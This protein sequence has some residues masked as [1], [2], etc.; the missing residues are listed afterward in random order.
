MM[1]ANRIRS[2]VYS[3]RTR[4][5]VL[6]L[7][8][9]MI[10]VGTF[11][12]LGISGIQQ[13]GRSAEGAGSETLRAQA[14]EYLIQLTQANAAKS[15]LILQRVRRDA[16]ILAQYTA[17][18]F[19]NPTA[20]WD[21]QYWRAAE[22]MTDGPDGQFYNSTEDVTSIFIPNFVERDD[23]L[24]DT[25]EASAYLDFALPNI[26]EGDPNSV[27]VYLGTEGEI[28]RYY[29][30]IGLGTILPADFQVT[31]RPWYVSAAPEQ[32]PQRETTWS[33][34]YDDATGRGLLVTAAA[35]VYLSNGGFFGVIGI[36][37]TLADLRAE[38]EQTP[39]AAGG[40]LFL[41][42]REGRAIALPRR[43]YQDILGR[44][45]ELDEFGPPLD[46]APSSFATSVLEPMLKGLTGFATLNLGGRELFAAYAP[47]EST[48]W[49]I[50]SI[51]EAEQ[52]LAA[53]ADLRVEVERSTDRLIARRF[54]PIGA[55]ILVAVVLI[56]LFWS[57][58][59][60]SPIQKLA[61]TARQIGSGNLE[62]VVTEAGDTRTTEIRILAQALNTMRQ[63]L[64]ELIGSLEGR[65][66]DRTYE[67]ERRARQLEA[68]AEVAH[69]ATAVLDPRTLISQ[70]VQLISE[71]FGFYHAGLFLLDEPQEYAVLRAASSE[72]GRRMLARRH[73]LRVGQ[74]GIVGY[75]TARGQARIALDVGEDAVFFDNPDLPETR[76]EMAL[77]LRVRGQIIG[78]LDVQSTQEAAFTTEDVAVLQ[79][80]ADQVALAISNAQL[81]RQAQERLEELRRAYGEYS[82]RAWIEAAQAGQVL[83]FRYTPQGVLA[84]AEVW[85]P[86]MS[87]ALQPAPVAGQRPEP[88]EG[89]RPEPAE[90]QRPE[91]AE[92]QR[93]DG[94]AEGQPAALALPIQVHGQDIGVLDV[95]KPA[96]A[97]QWEPEETELVHAVV[98]QLGLALESARLYQD[99]QR[100]AA[101]EQLVSE[102]TARMHE[103]LD[104]DSI[105]Q[106]A[107]REMGKT[108]GLHDVTIRLEVDK[109]RTD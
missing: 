20:F 79:T 94:D 101:R 17:S 98:E 44:P 35:P 26:Y 61:A 72:G 71:R 42:D 9:T 108:L 45:P 6:L 31:G 13:A 89:Q 22:H 23:L 95:R 76:S 63:Q 82:Q 43:G 59:L 80:L 96:G 67:L 39:F 83:G 41:V 100:R 49:S 74:E 85:Y 27:A 88:A 81:Y 25:L 104:V 106:T 92:G 66:A 3:I 73:R 86:E 50:G 54:L 2:W 30:N 47:L 53:I 102:I 33:E 70:V 93:D 36:D 16:E 105:L 57:G 24:L 11:A 48:G 34:V 32:D 28:T 78:A 58:R 4:L 52:M 7:T 69:A 56:G 12:Y 15:D 103:T 84:D 99:A 8:L 14:Q 87:E 37:V 107:V 29:P 75:V 19:D 46:T 40:Y 90:G 10:S 91:P 64:R 77:P 65:V 62:A 5:L 55:A 1:A 38:I 97:S 18:I 21:S 109:D 60:T 51:V 68:A